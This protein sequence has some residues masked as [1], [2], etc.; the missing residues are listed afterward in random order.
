[1]WLKTLM[2]REQ[3]CDYRDAYIAVK[4]RITLA[5]TNNDNIRKKKPAVTN[6]TPFTS[7]ITKIYST[8]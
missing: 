4:G 7:R 3:L 5:G 1:M 2:I 6:N 8:L